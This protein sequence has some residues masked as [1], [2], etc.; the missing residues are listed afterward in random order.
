METILLQGNKIKYRGI[1]ALA[2]SPYAAHLKHLDL[3]G[4]MIGD[5]GLKALSE[6][7]FIKKLEVLK[8]WK[9]EIGDESLELIVQAL[10]TSSK[11]KDS[12][13]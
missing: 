2:K 6:S 1:K 9:N 4:N 3:W 11:C 8:L 13:A 10:L 5:I 7:P 12:Y